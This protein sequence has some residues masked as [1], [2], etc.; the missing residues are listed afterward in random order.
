MTA[1][2]PLTFWENMSKV[3]VSN[4]PDKVKLIKRQTTD[5][6]P[7]TT[8]SNLPG[9]IFSNL[10][11]R[12]KDVFPRL[13]SK[14]WFSICPRLLGSSFRE[15]YLYSFHLLILWHVIAG[16]KKMEKSKCYWENTQNFSNKEF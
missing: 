14:G 8:K 1:N 16:G 5:D 13:F 4:E 10:L 7:K 15:V 11:S 9:A 2:S 3:K 6:K 12:A